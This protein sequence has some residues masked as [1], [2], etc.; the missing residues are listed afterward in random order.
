MSI[1]FDDIISKVTTFPTKTVAVACAEDSAVL[2]AVRAAKEKNIANAILVGDT[3][4]IEA[5]AK[6]M[7]MDLSGYEIIDA[8][9]TMEAALTAVKLVHDG[10][11]DIYMKGLI[12][13]K[14]FLKGLLD[15]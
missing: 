12:D 1:K 14:S 11:A 4:K 3:D 6:E 10:K 2:E 15:K 13:S 8:K 9:D 5:I 7:N